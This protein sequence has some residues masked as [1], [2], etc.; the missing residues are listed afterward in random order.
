MWAVTTVGLSLET[1]QYNVIRDKTLSKYLIEKKWESRKGFET[2]SS[3]A[4]RSLP[5]VNL[6]TNIIL[7]RSSSK[8]VSL[9]SVDRPTQ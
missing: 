5:Q 8:L 3:E 4:D 9:V 7:L 6:T 1:A 2:C